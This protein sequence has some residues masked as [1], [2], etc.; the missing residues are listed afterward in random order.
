MRKSKN[1]RPHGSSVLPREEIL[2][3][4]C[5]EEESEQGHSQG[6]APSFNSSQD[7]N[8]LKRTT[9]VTIVTEE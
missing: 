4:K 6:S 2:Q 8:S 7:L 1:F 9:T 3:S 5:G